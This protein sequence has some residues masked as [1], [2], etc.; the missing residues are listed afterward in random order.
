MGLSRFLKKIGPAIPIF[1]DVIGGLMGDSSARK[2]ANRA[3]AANREAAQNAHQWEVADLRKAGL[4]P[5]LSGTGGGGARMA[6]A[7][8]ADTGMMARAVSSSAQAYR[9]RQL[10]NAQIENLQTSTAKTQAETKNLNTIGVDLENTND[11][12]WGTGG[13][14]GQVYKENQA[15][16]E[17]T[18]QRILESR[19]RVSSAQEQT[20]KEKLLNDALAQSPEL[21]KWVL[22]ASYME[23]EKIN[24]AL[25]GAR[26]A[27]DVVSA[28]KTLLK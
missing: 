10:Y 13:Q 24:R 15:K 16:L 18:V 5:I 23:Y 2:A 6:G 3:T 27:S 25:S 9:D 12:K 26:T 22:S 20:R 17:E 21:Q 28:L 4:N 1:G 11:A 19:A 8:T 14:K 7:P